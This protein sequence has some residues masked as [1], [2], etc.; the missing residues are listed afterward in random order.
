MI[1]RPPRSTLFPYTTLFRSRHFAIHA[2][3]G[4][5]D[6]HLFLAGDRVSRAGRRLARR[7]AGVAH[8]LHRGVGP[9]DDVEHVWIFPIRCGKRS[10]RRDDSVDAFGARL[11]AFPIT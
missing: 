9:D 6:D 1:R 10:S 11:V 5:I 2:D 8:A 4:W 3:S 7:S